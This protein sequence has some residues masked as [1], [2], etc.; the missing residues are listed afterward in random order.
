MDEQKE[1]SNVYS[2]KCP[3]LHSC[4][5]V[6]LVGEDVAKQRHIERVAPELCQLMDKVFDATQAFY[7]D[8]D[9]LNLP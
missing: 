1:T 3:Y 8:Y 2:N 5:V 6:Q 4:A 9:M 7:A